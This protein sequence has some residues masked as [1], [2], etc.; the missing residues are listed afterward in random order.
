MKIYIQKACKKNI[1]FPKKKYFLLWLKEIFK[2]KK[3][4]ITIRLV[5]IKEIQFLNKKYRNKNLPT[6]V[7]S[8]QSTKQINIKKNFFFYIGDIILCAS[9]INKEAACFKKNILE[10]WAHMSIHSALHLLNYKHDT[11]QDKKKMENIEKKIM[12][13]LGFHNP[14]YI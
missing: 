1:F 9:Y 5:N 6:N 4:E 10:Y 2:N 14:Y 8:F 3:I 11:Y 13:K 12:K 7:L